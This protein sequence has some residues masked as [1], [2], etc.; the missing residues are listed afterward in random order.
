MKMLKSLLK[1]GFKKPVTR[2]YPFQKRPPFADS[3][4][5]IDMDPNACVYCGICSKR[6]PTDA[7]KVE[8][9]PKSWTLNPHRCIVC[10]YCVEVCPKHCITM[11]NTHR[12]PS[13]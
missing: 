6:C 11:D 7:I 12:A 1:M 5:K 13:A 9:D 3:R 8:R 4:G 2:K 10:G